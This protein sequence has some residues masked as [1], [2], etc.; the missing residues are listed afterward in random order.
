MIWEHFSANASVEELFHFWYKIKK[1]S[2]SSLG[3][4]SNIYP[5]LSDWAVNET[6]E[7]LLG[8]GERREETTRLR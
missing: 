2:L 3:G 1:I 8:A 7:T 4:I 6:G 5:D